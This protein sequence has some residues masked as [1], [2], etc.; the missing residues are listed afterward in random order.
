MEIPVIASHHPRR[1]SP[2]NTGGYPALSEQLFSVHVAMHIYRA[3]AMPSFIP[4]T[5][6]FQTPLTVL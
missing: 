6:A 2:V 3:D 4:S 5:N 1:D